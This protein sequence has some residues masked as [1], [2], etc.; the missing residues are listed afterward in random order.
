MPMT[1]QPLALA[2]APAEPKKTRQRTAQLKLA[3]IAT[4]QSESGE[5]EKRSGRASKAAAREQDELP[6]EAEG[7]GAEPLSQSKSA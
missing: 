3:G 1:L 7:A 6:L 4:I 2:K 5:S